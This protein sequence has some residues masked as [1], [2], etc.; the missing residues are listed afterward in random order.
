[1]RI[2]SGRQVWLALGVTVVAVAVGYVLA[3]WGLSAWHRSQAVPSAGAPALPT[4][5]DNAPPSVA[6]TDAYGPLG[7]VSMVY[8]GTD[9]RE[10]L[11]GSVE[12]PWL[13]ISDRTGDYRAISAPGLPD[14]AQGSV[15]V[16][17]GGD[18][19]AWATGDG[20]ALYDPVTDETREV[21]LDGATA[22]GRFS[23]DDELLLVH[24]GGLR[25]L[26]VSDGE[27]VTGVDDTAEEV[28]QH[29]AWRPDGSAVDYV[30][31][32][33]L[34]TLAVPDGDTTTAP[35][36]F[37]DD[38]TLAWSPTGEQ[39][40]GLQEVDGVVRLLSASPEGE[41]VGEPVETRVP[42]VSLQRLLGFSGDRTLAVS[43]YFLESGA[44]ERVVDIP[45]DGGSPVDITTLPSEGEN[46][47]GSATLAVA[48]DSLRAGSTDYGSHLWP[49]SNQARLMTCVLVGI[50]GLGLWVTRRPRA[51]RRR[52]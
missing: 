21:A 4:A 30:E 32:Q 7:T 31:G 49:W 44:V 48:A 2:A 45:L 13:A 51:A 14:P 6:T 8:A 1:M 37:R 19:L 27:V 47:T 3:T 41:Q 17:A 46:W 52:R 28:A 11:F 23:A 25:V 10:G 15:S 50:F 38:T 42:G 18:L 26:R 43:A 20:V 39:L 12:N 34:V 33:Q 22:V 29:A 9:V 35:T 40:V 5:V 36:T 16:T 24:A